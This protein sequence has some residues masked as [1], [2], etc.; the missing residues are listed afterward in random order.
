V[1]GHVTTVE[2]HEA[3]REYFAQATCSCRKWTY[4]TD[5]YYTRS[6]ASSAAMAAARVHRLVYL[7]FYK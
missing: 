7:D 4:T 1:S 3:G 6:A 5:S 2:V